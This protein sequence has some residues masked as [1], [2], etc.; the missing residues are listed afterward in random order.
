MTDRQS[1]QPE[2]GGQQQGGS[3][4]P[5]NN[6]NNGNNNNAQSMRPP[7]TTGTSTRQQQATSTVDPQIID[8]ILAFITSV[9]EH[10]N[11]Q[12]KSMAGKLNQ[13]AEPNFQASTTTQLDPL[14]VLDPVE[15]SLGYLYF[16]QVYQNSFFFFE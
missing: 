3:T 12:M 11:D 13:L 2:Q 9:D 7:T 14:T 5:E 1:S 8:E 15:H 10:D 16:L 4:V 6:N